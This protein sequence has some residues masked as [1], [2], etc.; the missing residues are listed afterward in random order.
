MTL[1]ISEEYKNLT[2]KISPFFL[3]FAKT[4]GWK[5]LF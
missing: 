5:F 1:E 3:E 4:I 2:W